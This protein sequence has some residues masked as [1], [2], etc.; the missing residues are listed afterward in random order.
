[1]KAVSRRLKVLRADK[2]ITQRDVARKANMPLLR[3]WEIENGYR[4]PDDSEKARIAGV[5]GATA[6]EVFGEAVAS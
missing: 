3:Y 6:D 1:M 5:L 2:D 4:E